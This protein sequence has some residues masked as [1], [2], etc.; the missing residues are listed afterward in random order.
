MHKTFINKLRKEKYVKEKILILKNVIR[1]ITRK[2]YTSSII[3]KLIY[4][5]H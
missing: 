5:I 1:K 2:P 4:K 3:R